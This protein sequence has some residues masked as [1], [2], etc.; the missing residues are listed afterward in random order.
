MAPG[1]ARGWTRV[2]RAQGGRSACLH[3]FTLHGQS[4]KKVQDEGPPSKASLKG[5]HQTGVYS[6][7]E[8]ESRA[9]GAG[10]VT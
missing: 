3:G 7:L 8:A 10:L 5:S 1:A 9:Q 4:S 2:S 6:P